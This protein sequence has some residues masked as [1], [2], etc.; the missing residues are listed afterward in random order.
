MIMESSGGFP[1]STI[2]STG[3]RIL[4]A[5]VAFI[6]VAVVGFASDV[7]INHHPT[8]RLADEIGLGIA[9]ALLVYAY[10]RQ[11][12]RLLS[13]KVRVIRDMNAFVRNELQVL[14]ATLNAPEKSRVPA[15][16]RS[17]ARIDWALREL[18]PGGTAADI[19][20]IEAEKTAPDPS[21][22]SA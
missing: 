6:V 22:R 18:L 2:P 1:M 10:E 13:E 7:T 5:S 17:V 8:W 9:T 11:R 15:V 3:Q 14:Y 4:L 19:S 21:R 16:E 12:S 20:A